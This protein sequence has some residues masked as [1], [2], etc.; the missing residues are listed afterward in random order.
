MD[1]HQIKSRLFF[2]IFLVIISLLF[3]VIYLFN[4][5][6]L[7]QLK[8]Q[9]RA[10][11]VSIRMLPIT[12]QRGEIFDRNIDQPLVIN[13]DSF[14][15]NIIPGELDDKTLDY[16]IGKLASFLEIPY[17]DIKKKIPVNYRYLYQPVEIKSSVDLNTIS[18]IAEHK[19]DFPGVTWNNKP[20]R[21]Y[22]YS[23]SL[24][25]LLGYV[26]DITIEE[27]QVLYNKGYTLNS[28]IGKSGVEKEYDSV[29]RGKDGKQFKTVDVKGRKIE[30]RKVDDIPPENGKTLVLTID[31]HI[32]KLAEEALGERMG[33]VVVL[34][35]ASGEILAMVSY[36]WFNPNKFY[37]T[38]AKKYYRKTAL[39]PKHPFLNRAIQSAYAPASTFKI[40]MTTADL[41]EGAFPTDKTITCNGSIRVGD[42]VFNCYKKEG[43]GSLILHEALA[44]SCDV[45]FYTLGLEYLGIDV[46][47]DYARRFGYGSY[48]GIDLPGE[49]KGLVPTPSWKEE[50]FNTKWVGGDT[51]NI[52]IGQGYLN[53][54]PLQMADMVAMTVN[55]GVIYKPHILKEIRDPV[56]GKVLEKIK[57]EIL[58]T[59][60]ISKKNF[61]IVQKY[62]RGVITDGT[63]KVVI[64]TKAVDIAG[65][66][67]TGEVGL[68]DRWNAWFAANGPYGAEPEDQIVVV[69]MVEATNKWEW[70]AIRAAN[71]IFQGIFAGETYDE[72]IDSLHWGWLRNKREVQ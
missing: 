61:E 58:T 45:Y 26:G 6:V 38:E 22:I 30:S 31:R 63:A 3:F 40:I 1:S 57:P 32:Q 68:E 8:Y 67:G 47:S 25:H 2:I 7:N 71:I 46:I 72:A 56:T 33:S 4:L 10:R 11:N 48:T 24:T 53:V 52:S 5:Q 16:T 21:N 66:T 37:T 13:I 14:A 35:P 29:L 49:I 43:H 60:S 15:I 12:A 59:S 19:E 28:Q 65:K 39:D 62:M 44:Q 20:I 36:P 17:S 54:T 50:V 23:G 9:D 41:E 55:K 34:K 64:T 69:T 18:Y 42:R 27:Y 70:W 51:V